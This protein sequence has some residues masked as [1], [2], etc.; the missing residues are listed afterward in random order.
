MSADLSLLYQAADLPLFQNKV[1]RSAAEAR[2][3]QRG[4]IE[5]KGCRSCAFVFNAAFDGQKMDYGSAYQNEQANSPCFRRFLSEVIDILVTNGIK[6]GKVAEIGCGKGYFL[7]LLSA[8]GFKVTGFDPAYEGDDPRIIKDYFSSKYSANAEGVVLRHTL[9]HIE[10]PLHLLR[11]IAEANGNKGRIYIE[12]P[13]FEWICRR[14]AFWD[15]FYE[16]CNYFTENTLSALFKKAKVG[17]IFGGQYIYLVGALSDLRSALPRSLD[18]HSFDL[19]GADFKTKLS[20]YRSTL[21][22]NGETVVWGA[23]AKAV[24]FLNLLDPKRKYFDFVIDINTK[25]QNCFI[26]G[27]AHE[28]RDPDSLRE[29][30]RVK[31]IFVMNENYLSEIQDAAG[32]QYEYITLT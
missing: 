10:N 15:I 21:V 24:T 26:P 19:S 6:P 4:A 32:A 20:N 25:K 12:V 16:H 2:S 27:S 5:L 29:N 7:N 11:E 18:S 30:D 3:V 14:S 28:V 13:S 9:E 22:S 1:C 17:R 8:A 31:R 23:G